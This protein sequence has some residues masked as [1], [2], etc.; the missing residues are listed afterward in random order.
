MYL[1]GL[2]IRND[3]FDKTNSQAT[4]P[5]SKSVSSGCST[6][7][8]VSSAFSTTIGNDNNEYPYQELD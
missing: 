4:S 5:L 6:E 1:E 2:P 8:V 3:N 7:I